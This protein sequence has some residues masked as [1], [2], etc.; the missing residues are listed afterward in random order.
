MVD[1]SRCAGKLFS[2]S[3]NQITGVKRLLKEAKELSEPNDLF[4]AY[5]LE[6]RSFYLP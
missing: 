6:V 2:Y 3:Y 5:P 1:N 4:R